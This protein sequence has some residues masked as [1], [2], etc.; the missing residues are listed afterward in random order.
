LYQKSELRKLTEP[1]EVPRAKIDKYSSDADAILDAS[2]CC[3]ELPTDEEKLQAHRITTLEELFFLLPDIKT[4]L[5]PAKERT[6][7]YENP[8][9]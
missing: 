2:D 4:C 8:H 9:F 3:L 1:F 6:Y 7:G 5:D